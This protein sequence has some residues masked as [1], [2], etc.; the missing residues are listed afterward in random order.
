MENIEQIKER[1]FKDFESNHKIDKDA[2]IYIM[3][4]YGNFK[5]VVNTKEFNV[6]FQKELYRILP[7]NVL[8]LG[9]ICRGCGT[10]MGAY[11]ESLC[12]MCYEN[13]GNDLYAFE[14]DNEDETAKEWVEYYSSRDG[15]ELFILFRTKSEIDL[16]LI[17]NSFKPLKYTNK[18]QI[19]RDYG[20]FETEGQAYV[21]P[22]KDMYLVEE[23]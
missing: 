20:D 6:E 1:L 21:I 12:T 15:K 22:Y 9:Y 18:M 17:R 23:L 8:T 3:K 7:K 19:Q 2:P 10:W 14:E 5:D 4:L 16:D 11:P 13:Y